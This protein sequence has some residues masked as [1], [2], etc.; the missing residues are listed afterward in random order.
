MK[1]DKSILALAVAGQYLFAGTQGGEILVCG[2]GAV[3]VI[4]AEY[5]RS[6]ASTRTSGGE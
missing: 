2:E 5:G 1:H 6:T 3:R 4:G